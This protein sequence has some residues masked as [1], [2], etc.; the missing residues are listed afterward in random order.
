[1][2]VYTSLIH[3][4]VTNK[5]GDVVTTSITNFDLHDLARTCTTY[6]VNQCF[7]VTP[8]PAQKE[9]M[10]F[11]KKH[12][13]EGYG[14]QYNPDRR[15]A[16][17]CMEVADSIEDTC[18]TIQKIHGTHPV[19]VA[20]SAR[21]AKKAIKFEVLRDRLKEDSKPHLLLFGTGWG[22]AQRVLDKVDFALEPID[23]G[24]GYNHLPVRAAVAVVLDR[25]LS[26]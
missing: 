11:I 24:T 15:Q 9:M 22:L 19:L 6:G 1:M 4:P 17:E 14:S 20:T 10:H 12:W 7:I 13:S 5:N 16:F 3:H 18:L 8:N 2:N 23:A 21:K 25:L 26:V